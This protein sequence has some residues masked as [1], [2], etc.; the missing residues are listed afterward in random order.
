MGVST[1]QATIGTS[2]SQVAAVNP[3]RQKVIF[4][5]MDPATTIFLGALTS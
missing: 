3:S 1:A 4:T 2:Q 5:N